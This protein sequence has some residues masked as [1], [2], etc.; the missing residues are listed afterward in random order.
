MTDKPA[1]PGDMFGPKPRIE[2]DTA[3]GSPF[4]RLH[5]IATSAAS[6]WTL[7]D[8]GPYR[9]PAPSKLGYWT[10]HNVMTGEVREALAFL[11]E[12]GVIDIDTERLTQWEQSGIPLGREG[13][14]LASEREN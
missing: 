12:L 1:I 11:L 4:D 14:R 5:Y 10:P 3:D 2:I 6:A 7:G 9:A 8:D 13:L